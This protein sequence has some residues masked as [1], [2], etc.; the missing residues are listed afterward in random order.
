MLAAAEYVYLPWCAYTHHHGDFADGRAA[1]KHFEVRTPTLQ[2]AVER[3]QKT[4]A[5]LADAAEL[6]FE[7]DQQA[8][9]V[10]DAALE[11]LQRVLARRTRPCSA[12]GT[13]AAWCRWFT[14]AKVTEVAIT[15]ISH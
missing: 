2:V 11:F 6:V 12:L 10:S 5:I 9:C 3:A 1:R 15:A 4:R 7:V 14:D 8:N 13:S